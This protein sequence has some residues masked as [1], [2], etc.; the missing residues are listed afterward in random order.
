[1]TRIERLACKEAFIAGVKSAQAVVEVE[2]GVRIARMR[3]MELAMP[4]DGNKYQFA[5][6][7]GWRSVL[8][9]EVSYNNGK[10]F[11]RKGVK[12]ILRPK[13]KCVYLA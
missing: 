2:D 3:L 5:W 1:M 4:A 13:Q 6:I 11:R 7:K 8:R 9:D 12:I 10:L